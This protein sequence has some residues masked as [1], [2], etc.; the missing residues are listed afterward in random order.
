MTPTKSK[1]PDDIENDNVNDTSDIKSYQREGLNSNKPTTVSV[2]DI[3]G[4]SESNGLLPQITTDSG[5][6][7]NRQNIGSFE[8]VAE[9][10][11]SEEHCL[12]TQG[13]VQQPSSSHLLTQT[14]LT[15]VANPVHRVRSEQS[16]SFKTGSEVAVK[17]KYFTDEKMLANMSFQRP[18][19]CAR[20]LS[21]D[22]LKLKRNG[23]IHL[24]TDKS[25]EATMVVHDTSITK[26]NSEGGGSISEHVER[27]T[28][29]EEAAKVRVSLQGEHDQSVRQ[30]SRG[31]AV[32]SKRGVV[33]DLCAHAGQSENNSDNNAIVPM[34]VLLGDCEG[35]E[36]SGNQISDDR[37]LSR[38]PLGPNAIS[39]IPVQALQSDE[40]E[41]PN[42][43][44]LES[45]CNR[46]SAVPLS[47]LPK[48]GTRKDTDTMYGRDT[49]RRRH[50]TGVSSGS[51]LK[52]RLLF[53]D[54]SDSSTSCLMRSSHNHSS[55]GF[56]PEHAAKRLKQSDGCRADQDKGGDQSMR[57]SRILPSYLQ[58]GHSRPSFDSQCSHQSHRQFWQSRCICGSEDIKWVAL[59][60]ECRSTV[61]Q[62]KKKN[63]GLF[64]RSLEQ[65][66]DSPQV[67]QVSL[68]TVIWGSF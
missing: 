1:S 10:V 43:S 21:V 67:L 35:R 63:V 55:S 13:I 61:A 46:V 23:H 33:S 12:E 53:T 7:N 59:C 39:H 26:K 50:G 22:L 64:K 49:H 36:R 27:S 68:H 47:P 38:S 40:R 11:S 3:E 32:C 45:N 16:S 57:P 54:Q 8:R 2:E 58:P 62:L 48:L 15:T 34:R 51:G 42:Q 9:I 52:R 25:N 30:M 18:V 44:K 20:M 24:A 19:T 6:A 17:S 41:G 29:A 65:G 14:T 4:H 5:N 66:I 56:L 31:E 37:S 60:G 28:E